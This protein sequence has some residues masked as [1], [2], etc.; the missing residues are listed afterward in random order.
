M[1][2][3]FTSISIFAFD[4]DDRGQPVQVRETVVGGDE[5]EAVEEAKEL[6]KDHAGTLVVKREGRPA[7]GEE[8]DLVVVFQTGR[9]G[10]FD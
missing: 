5:Q 1:P 10:D 7:V 6:A 3:A 8:G 2:R 9:T 4:V